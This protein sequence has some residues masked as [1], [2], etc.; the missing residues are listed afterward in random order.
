[1]R[2]RHDD[3]GIAAVIGAIIVLAILGIA[4]VYVNAFYVPRQGAALEVG[5]GESAEAS[6]V[7][8]ASTL[9]LAP[10][11][12]VVHDVPLRV[13]RSTPPLMAGVVLTP[14]RAEGTLELV[15]ASSSLSLS[16]VVPAPAQGVPANDPTREP[17]AGGKMRV[18]LVGTSSTMQALGALRATTGGAYVDESAALLEGGAV[19]SDT[20]VGSAAIAPP[21]LAVV[22]DVVSWRIPLLAGSASAV[23]G[24]PAA[25]VAL[26]PG[27]EAQLG[28]GAKVD[29]LRV[30]LQT[31]RLAAWQAALE[32]VVGS[33]GTIGVVDD[34]DDAGTITV[35]FANVEPKLFVV[36]YQV[37]LAD[38]A[39]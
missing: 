36:R 34:G 9:A 20:E 12:P 35:T 10:T 24:S 2:S 37:S 7:D 25:Q 17:V 13:E 32:E 30:A 3:Q 33:R 28:G 19:L 23:S 14:A 8:L 15:G 27:P 5:A 31:T 26:Q 4:L 6:L 29:E 11:G 1:M 18:H 39:G 16:V 21:S 38:R 22:G